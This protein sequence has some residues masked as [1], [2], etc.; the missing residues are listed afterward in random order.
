MKTVEGE[1]ITFSGPFYAREDDQLVLNGSWVE[2]PK[3]GIQFKV[4]S[5][6]HDLQIDPEGLSHFL[7]NHP[8]IK[9]IG[10]VKAKRI[11]DRFGDDFDKVITET[12]EA[13]THELK[14][15]EETVSRIRHVWLQ[16]RKFNE[17]NTLLASFGLTAH[18]ISTLVQKLGN[19]AQSVLKD[20]PYCLI[21]EIPGYGFRKADIIALKMGVS[22]D[23]FNRV[24]AGIQYCVGQAVDRGDCWIEREQ[25]IERAN[26]CLSMDVLNSR[27]IIIQSLDTLISEGK[28]SN[29]CCRD[30]H[31]VAKPQ[32]WECENDLANALLHT[33]SKS[34]QYFSNQGD[35]ELESIVLKVEPHL[36]QGQ[37]KAVVSALKNTISVISGGA[38]SGKTFAIAAL[39]KVL[40]AHHLKVALAAPTGKAA[41]RME[42]V[43]NH[44]ASTLHRLLGYTGK[45]YKKNEEDPIDADVVI[46]DEVSMIDVVLGSRLINAIDFT[47]TTLVLVG[48]HN[49][50]PPVGPGNLLRDIVRTKSVPMVLLDQVIRQAGV[51]K[52]NS[53]A[54][55]NGEV[56]TN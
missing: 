28:L 39:T 48:D 6:S 14:I 20:N 9:G 12:P 26:E 10:K 13:L 25:L 31:L 24:R 19:N 40:K 29:I 7:A 16:N 56:S 45:Q 21:G 30:R 2:H 27:E 22:K 49:Q 15:P 36:N 50:L 17:T 38:G 51:L 42:E 23:D 1:T 46:I 4:S 32:M 47:R 44:P 33:A 53:T 37:L 3:Y 11:A 41:K 35:T 18:Q 43:V 5:I 54:L 52:E 55:L 34:N 8:E